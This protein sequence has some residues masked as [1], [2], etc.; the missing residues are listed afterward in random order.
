MRHYEENYPY[1]YYWLISSEKEFDWSNFVIRGL[2]LIKCEWSTLIKSFDKI[3]N[4]LRTCEN[5]SIQN[6]LM[7][8][9]VC[10][11]FDKINQY[12]KD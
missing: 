7:L 8:K 2:S 12:E 3:E 5:I 10:R 9:C 4:K 11:K 1:K 6:N